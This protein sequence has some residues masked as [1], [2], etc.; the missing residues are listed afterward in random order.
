MNT[1]SHKKIEAKIEGMHDDVTMMSL[2][3]NYLTKWVSVHP[4]E[5]QS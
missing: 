4:L 1:N 2:R 3:Q 5:F